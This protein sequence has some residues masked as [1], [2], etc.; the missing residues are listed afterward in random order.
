MQDDSVEYK[1][2]VFELVHEILQNS[3][4]DVIQLRLNEPFHDPERI[5]IILFPE[6]AS[7]TTKV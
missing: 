6:P 4:D 5:P 1:T 2:N 3:I 7:G